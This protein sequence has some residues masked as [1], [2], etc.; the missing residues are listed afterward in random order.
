MFAFDAPIGFGAAGLGNL[1]GEMDPARAHELCEEAWASGMR[2]F[3]TAPHYGLG[4]SESRLG[5]F[6]QTRPRQ[7]YLLSTKVGRLLEPVAN[8]SGELDL[9]ND[10][11]VPAD[12]ARRWDFTAGGIERSITDSLTRTGLESIDIAYLHDPDK[13]D[14]GMRAAL[15]QGLAALQDLKDQGMVRAIGIGSMATEAFEM[16]LGIA[17]MDVV[18][19]AGRYTLLEQPAARALDACARAGTNVVIASVF[20]SGLL[21]RNDPQAGGRYEYGAVPEAILARAQEAARIC[22]DHDVDLPAAALQFP[23]R[24]PAVV[25]VIT[26]VNSP[27]QAEQNV[28]RAKEPIPEELWDDLAAAGIIPGGGTDD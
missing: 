28:Q 21:A 22:Q 23:L 6:L 14:I 27:G 7:E 1:F 18:M 9:D 19:V 20:N 13:A 10:F 26:G 5:E 15:T 4:L 17:P 11:H 24:H 8:P 2:Y 16:A 25:S 12:F 3:D